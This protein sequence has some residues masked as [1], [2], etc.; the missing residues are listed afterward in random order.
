M[1]KSTRRIS[2][3]VTGAARGE[4][5]APAYGASKAGLN[6]LSQSLAK[7]LASRGIYVFSLAPGW[8]ETEMAAAHLAGAAGAELLA[9]HPLGFERCELSEDLRSSA[10]GGASAG[11]ERGRHAA[12]RLDH[13][14]AHMRDAGHEP[15]PLVKILR[16]PPL[17]IAEV[18]LAAVEPILALR[19]AAAGGIQVPLLGIRVFLAQQIHGIGVGIG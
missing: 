15:D 8:V 14:A 19:F 2:A 18:G 1:T 7:A 3:L 5:D 10:L 16:V 13:A 11:I 12:G 17:E 9:Q 6:S 4:P